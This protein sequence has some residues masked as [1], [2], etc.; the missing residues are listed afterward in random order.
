MQVNIHLSFCT[1]ID[2]NVEKEKIETTGNYLSTDSGYII[3]YMEQIEDSLTGV[4][5]TTTP[6]VIT[7]DRKGPCS[8]TF[9]MEENKAHPCAYS[10]PY[11]ILDMQVKATSIQNALTPNGGHLEISYIL[12][13]DGETFHTLSL[14]I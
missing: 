10:T 5:I 4:K 3:S 8:V 1:E 7:I 13:M 12:D 9:T 11:G 14:T 2:G 6:N